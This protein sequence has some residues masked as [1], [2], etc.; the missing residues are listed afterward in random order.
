M[1]DWE[2]SQ[3]TAE[4]TRDRKST[5]NLLTNLVRRLFSDSIFK[6]TFKCNGWWNLPNNGK[7]GK[8][9]KNLH[10]LYCKMK[11]NWVLV[12]N[13]NFLISIFLQPNG[14][15][16]WYFKLRLFELG[17][18]LVWNIYNPITLGCKDLGIRKW[19]F[20]ANIFDLLVSL[21]NIK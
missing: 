2:N 21:I 16:L 13:S 14:V 8:R 20:S 9:N 6:L 5:N 15:N 4:T 1:F 17:E 19:E 10:C 11:R 3:L 18:F 12:L 7:K